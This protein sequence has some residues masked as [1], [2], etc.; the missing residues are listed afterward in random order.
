VLLSSTVRLLSTLLHDELHHPLYYTTYGE[1]L[2]HNLRAAYDRNA[3]ERNRYNKEP[4]KV[5]E[6][7]RFLALLHAERK[8]SLLELGAGPGTDSLFFHQHGLAV[9]ATDLSPEMIKHCHDK[10]LTAYVMDF[11]DVALPAR[12]FDAVYALNSL[13]HL[14]KRDLPHAF[15]RIHAILKPNG[16]FYFGVYGGHDHEGTLPN[17]SYKPPRFFSFYTDDHIQRRVRE[18]FDIVS[19]TPISLGE[20]TF[21]VQ[22]FVLRKAER[23]E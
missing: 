5:I 18:V 17:D 23:V 4:W 20:T 6:R 14:P 15:Q 16:L 1:T 22:S 10:G 9:T 3:A 2:K 12:S 11:S 8:H 7:Q 21:H 13:L 19:F